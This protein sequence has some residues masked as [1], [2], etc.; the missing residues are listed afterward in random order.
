MK[1]EHLT[2]FILMRDGKGGD[3]SHH[4]P[5]LSH[6]LFLINF[7]MTTKLRC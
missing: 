5:I 3:I 2:L 7:W 6:Q 4:M 1:K